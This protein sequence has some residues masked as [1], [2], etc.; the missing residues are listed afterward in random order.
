MIKKRA[1]RLHSHAHLLNGLDALV[2]EVG[3]S[4]LFLLDLG[5]NVALSKQFKGGSSFKNH[6]A[7]SVSA[8]GKLLVARLTCCERSASYFA[9]ACCGFISCSWRLSAGKR[10]FS[11]MASVSRSLSLL[12]AFLSC[13]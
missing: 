8:E 10:T 5:E 3:H 13:R 11:S 6:N 1:K 4:L 7:G 12:G 9:I 2:H